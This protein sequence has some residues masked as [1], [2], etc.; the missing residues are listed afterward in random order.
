MNACTQQLKMALQFAEE[1]S[2]GPIKPE[3]I[4]TLGQVSGRAHSLV[5][6][7]QS[8]VLVPPPKLG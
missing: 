8:D 3:N 5:I 4:S 6:A 2:R 7:L 1:I